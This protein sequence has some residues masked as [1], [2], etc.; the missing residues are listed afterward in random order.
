[1]EGRFSLVQVLTVLHPAS[2]LE[3]LIALESTCYRINSVMS[4]G[5]GG[6]K[7]MCLAFVL[8]HYVI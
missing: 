1:M 7:T 2:F 6:E 4:M 3:Q 8:Q 5:G